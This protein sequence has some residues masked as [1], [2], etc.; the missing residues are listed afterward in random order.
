MGEIYIKLTEKLINNLLNKK[1]E[2]LII[3]PK[4]QLLKMRN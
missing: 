1:C 4:G 2:I 3:D